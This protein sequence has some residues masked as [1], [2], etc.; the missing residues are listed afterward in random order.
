[1]ALSDAT[2]SMMTLRSASLGCLDSSSGGMS[3]SASL[4]L[5]SESGSFKGNS[6]GKLNIVQK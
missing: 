6:W 3:F 1:M 4:P 5:I 2:Q